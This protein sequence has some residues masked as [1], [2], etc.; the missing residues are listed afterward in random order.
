M[1]TVILM[2]TLLALVLQC[3]AAQAQV[4]GD[5]DIDKYVSR[6]RRQVEKSYEYRMLELKQRA[7]SEIRLLDVA[8]KGR[9][10]S[11]AAQAEAAKTVLHVNTYGYRAPWYRK[12]KIERMLQLKGDFEPVP[13]FAHELKYSSK[14]FAVAQTRIAERKNR[15]LAK[16]QCEAIDLEKQKQYALTTGLGEL[17]K[18]LKAG[19]LAPEP[20]SPRGVVTG[21]VYSEDKPSAIIERDVVHEGQ[22]IRGV[23]VVKIQKSRVEFDKQGQKWSQ[24]VGEL[25]NAAWS[26]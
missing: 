25:A 4:E 19:L 13:R 10:A 3:Q 2:L 22:T 20:K 15:I 26:N 17:E 1:R 14:R 8:D 11:L 23:K 9:Y 16:L 21:I 7:E 12:A 18:R 24:A 5:E 6:L